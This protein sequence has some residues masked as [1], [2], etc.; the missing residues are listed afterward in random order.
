MALAITERAAAEVKNFFKEQEYDETSALLRVGIVS[1]G[2]SGLNYS[3][4]IET[5]V[6][7]ENDKVTE[8][9]GVRVVVDRKSA[10]YLD[11]TTVDYYEGLEARGF[12]FKNP[13]A[14]RTCGCGQSFS[15]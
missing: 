6:D 15:V 7:E 2:C 8:H 10:L 1:G 4:N 3:L 11:E 13:N 9:H 14:A 5:E 12:Q